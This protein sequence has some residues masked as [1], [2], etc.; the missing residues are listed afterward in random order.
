[1]QKKPWQQGK[2][3]R[4]ITGRALDVAVD[5]RP[6]SS[7][8]KQ[9]ETFLLDGK[10]QV[11]IP[12]GFAHGFLAQRTPKQQQ[13]LGKGRLPRVRMGNDREAAAPLDLAREFLL[14]RV[15]VDS[16]EPLVSVADCS[17]FVAG[18]LIAVAGCLT[19]VAG[20]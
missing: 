2:L 3:V 5:L 7:T 11:Y 10:N 16:C 17:A 15:H 8:Y 18:C 14:R 6:D 13:F 19:A 1:M 4:T 9:Y 12:P 20:G